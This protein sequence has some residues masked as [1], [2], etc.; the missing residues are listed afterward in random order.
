[1]L[2]VDMA[3]SRLGASRGHRWARVPEFHAGQGEIALSLGLLR[4][5]VSLCLRVRQRHLPVV[6]EMSSPTD[7]AVPLGPPAAVHRRAQRLHRQNRLFPRRH[8]D[9]KT[10]SKPSDPAGVAEMGSMGG[11]GVMAQ[12]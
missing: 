5:F 7:R 4:V 2:V 3:A 8:E 12:R 10:Q 1:M 9:T 11:F 6:S